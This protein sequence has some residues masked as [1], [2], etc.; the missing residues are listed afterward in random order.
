MDPH[1]GTANLKITWNAKADS[2][3]AS[4]PLPTILAHKSL[5]YLISSASCGDVCVPGAAFGCAHI[6]L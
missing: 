2:V 5:F 1:F 6:P 3:E 4:F